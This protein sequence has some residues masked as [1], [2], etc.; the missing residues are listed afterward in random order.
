MKNQHINLFYGSVLHDIGKVVQRAEP[1]KKWHSKIGAD[2]LETFNPSDAIIDQVKY[3]HV[4]ELNEADLPTNDLAYITYI[5]DNI[6]TGVHE[7]NSDGKNSTKRRSIKNLEDIFNKFGE[8]PLK[9][10]FQPKLLDL[11]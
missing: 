11:S 8:I 2:F 10:Y 3:H 9:R 7:D 6:A 5:A 1:Q 4:A